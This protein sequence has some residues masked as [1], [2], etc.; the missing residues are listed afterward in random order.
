[1]VNESI[2]NGDLPNGEG[3]MVIEDWQADLKKVTMRILWDDPVS[4]QG[5]D[6]FKHIYLHKNHGS[7]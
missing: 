3:I 1:M 7:E 4:D 6:Y 5:K 2:E